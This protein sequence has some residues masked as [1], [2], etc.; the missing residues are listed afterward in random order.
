MRSMVEGTFYTPNHHH[1]HAA[2]RR[3]RPLHRLRRS[4]SPLRGG[5]SSAVSA[6]T[7]NPTNK[8]NGGDYKYLKRLLLTTTALALGSRSP[9]GKPSPIPPSSGWCSRTCCPPTRPTSPMSSASSGAEGAG[10]RSRHP[11]RRPA[12]LG[13]CRCAGH[14]IEGDIPD[15]IYFQGGD[16]KMADQK[17]ILEDLN[18]WIEKSPNLKA[19]LWPHNVDRLKNYPYL[20]YIY[21]PARPQPVI[22]KDWLDKL[23]IAP[24]QTVDEYGPS[25]RPSTT[26]ISMA[27]APP[28]TPWASPPRK[29]PTS[30][31]RSSTRPSASPAPG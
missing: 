4:P 13:L 27:T 29:I 14:H 28:A 7:F 5:G 8:H 26:P 12:V 23:G 17:G 19:A 11:D 18:P 16:A 20:L 25:S 22:R 31:T 21:P 1:V 2:S 24:P 6:S 30:S 9:P 3:G 10:H 15:L